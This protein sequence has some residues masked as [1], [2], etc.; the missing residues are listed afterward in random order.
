MVQSFNISIIEMVESCPWN[1]ESFAGSGD[2][3]RITAAHLVVVA[4]SL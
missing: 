4:K 1:V 3:N 2:Q